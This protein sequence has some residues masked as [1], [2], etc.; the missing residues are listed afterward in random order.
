MYSVLERIIDW[1]LLTA[2]EMGGENTV[3]G[4]QKSRSLETSGEVHQSEKTRELHVS[5]G[6]LINNGQN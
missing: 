4:V 5:S 2:Q 6:L 1:H 3:T